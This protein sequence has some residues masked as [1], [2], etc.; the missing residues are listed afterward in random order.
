MAIGANFN[1]RNRYLGEWKA[2][3]AAAD[4]RFHLQRVIVPE[5]SLLSTLEIV[6]DTSSSAEA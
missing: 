4:A 1:G 3:L 6:W 2:L 5:R